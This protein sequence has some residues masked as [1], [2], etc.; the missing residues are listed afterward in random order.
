MEAVKVL[1]MLHAISFYE[2][3]TNNRPV[4]IFVWK[5]FMRGSSQ[6]IE[7]LFKNHIDLIGQ[8]N[9]LQQ[10]SCFSS[11]SFS[12]SLIFT[13]LQQSSKALL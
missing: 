6:N 7:M 2:D 3:F 1:M 11:V 4:P 5:L 10:A 9:V 13:A 12:L 8:T